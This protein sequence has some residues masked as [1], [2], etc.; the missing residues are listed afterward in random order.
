MTVRFGDQVRIRP[1]PDGPEPFA[2]EATFTNKVPSVEKPRR[3]WLDPAGRIVI[4]DKSRLV[5]FFPQG[6][7]P[8]RIRDLMLVDQ[9]D[10]Q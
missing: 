9:S 7:I 5:V 2:I 10:S 6:F 4:A 8:P 3:I 1:T